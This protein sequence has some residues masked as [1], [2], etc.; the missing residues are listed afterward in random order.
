MKSSVFN[1]EIAKLNTG[2]T[3]IYNSKAGSFAKLNEEFMQTLQGLNDVETQKKYQNNIEKLKSVGFVVEDYVDEVKNIILRSNIAKY[4]SKKMGLVIAPT[5]NC[6]MKCPYCYENKSNIKMSES[7]IEGVIKFTEKWLDKKEGLS[8]VWYGG[9]PLLEI[10]AIRKLSKAFV[11]ICQNKNIPY[12]A[13]IITNGILLDKKIADILKEE[14]KVQFAQITLDG[15]KDVHDKSRPTR[16]GIS[17]FE[18]IINNIGNIKELF[19]ISVRINV[20]KQNKND[21]E[22][23]VHYMIEDKNWVSDDKVKIY[24]APVLNC[25]DACQIT[26]SDTISF[27]E[28]GQIYLKNMDYFVNKNRDTLIYQRYP[29]P[30]T[31]PC[32]AVVMSS[33]IIGPEGELYK[34][35]QEVGMKQKT[36]GN[37]FNGLEL[38]D[39]FHDYMSLNLPEVCFGCI[40]LPI[41][42]GGCPNARLRNNNQPNCYTTQIG[43]K[44]DLVRIF[45]IWHNKNLSKTMVNI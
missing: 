5:L 10:K 35:W 36:V 39:T 31:I 15:Y 23:L 28:F 25:Q 4:S 29:R 45:D 6:N 27:S 18:L 8:V 41:C 33:V 11:E 3:L 37:V 12:S 42:Q 43:L 17:S 21:I 9:E 44:E 38:N 7:V 40:Y 34:C 13:S 1:I 2:E 19:N 30:S 26:D 16:S 32:S 22:K 20:S 24:L 14:C